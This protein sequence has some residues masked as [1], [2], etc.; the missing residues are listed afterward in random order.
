MWNVT[1]IQKSVGRSF[2]MRSMALP[3]T[4][5]SR[6]GAGLYKDNKYFFYNICDRF[7]DLPHSI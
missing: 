3:R 6:R 2:S 1:G 7:R 4:S 5:V